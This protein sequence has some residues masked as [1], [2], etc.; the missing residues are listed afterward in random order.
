[1]HGP[2]DQEKERAGALSG[3]TFSTST[4]L[5]LAG[6][7]SGASRVTARQDAAIFNS[8]INDINVRRNALRSPGKSGYPG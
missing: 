6:Q 7:L 5:F 3:Y 1:M 8:D 4:I 2:I